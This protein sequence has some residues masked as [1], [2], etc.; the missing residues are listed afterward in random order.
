M[1]SFL[2]GFEAVLSMN[3][4]IDD[5]RVISSTT[6]VVLASRCLQLTGFPVRLK[7]QHKII[8][9]AKQLK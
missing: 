9:R 1:S 2:V 8:D 3:E 4:C 5:P 6:S 7:V